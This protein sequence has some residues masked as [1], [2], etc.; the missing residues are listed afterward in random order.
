MAALGEK[1]IDAYI[2]DRYLRRCDPRF[3]DAGRY[4]ER[5]TTERRKIGHQNSNSCQQISPLTLNF[6][7]ASVQREKK[8]IEA[9]PIP[10][11]VLNGQPSMDRNNIAGHVRLR[12]QCLR[13]PDRREFRQVTFP[14][15]AAKKNSPADYTEKNEV[16]NRLCYGQG[17][18]CQP[19]CNSRTTLYTYSPCDGLTPC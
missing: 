17:H 13:Y 18:L 19:Y 15:T 10:C 8:C 11:V 3:D 5:T 4:K 6:V 1:Q 14:V 9:A 12:P 16:K 7:T 2:A